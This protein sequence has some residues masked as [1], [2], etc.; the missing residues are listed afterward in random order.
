[1]L[2]EALTLS[3]AARGYPVA[4]FLSIPEFLDAARAAEMRC[5]VADLDKAGEGDPLGVVRLVEAQDP[6][7]PIILLTGLLRARSS[8]RKSAVF[9]TKP[10]DPALLSARILKTAR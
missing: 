1:M 5:L 2:R 6:G 10:V 3:L 9:M 7:L 8:L 4:A